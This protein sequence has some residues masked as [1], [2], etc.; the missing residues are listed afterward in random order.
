VGVVALV[1]VA[2]EDRGVWVAPMP[3]AQVVTASALAVDTQNRT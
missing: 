2:V 1:A 3:Q